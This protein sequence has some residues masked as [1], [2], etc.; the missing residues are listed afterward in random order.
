MNTTWSFDNTK[1]NLRPTIKPNL[2]LFT[3]KLQALLNQHPEIMLSSD[4]DGNVLAYDLEY[5]NPTTETYRR[6]CKTI[7]PRASEPQPYENPA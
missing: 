5:F 7:L 4:Q 6:D 2:I 1:L 3:Q